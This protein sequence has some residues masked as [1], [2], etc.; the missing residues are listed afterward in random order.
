MDER[1]QQ[2]DKSLTQAENNKRPLRKNALANIPERKQNELMNVLWARMTAIFGS[3]W[4]QNYGTQDQFSFKEWGDALQYKTVPEVMNA[5]DHF[6]EESRHGNTWPPSLPDFI[7]QCVPPN[8]PRK[9]IAFQEVIRNMGDWA[10]AEWSHVIVEAAAKAVGYFNFGHMNETPLKKLW[11][12]A[13]DDAYS[14]FINGELIEI[15]KALP[16]ESEVIIK[17]PEVG[18]KHIDL[19]KKDLKF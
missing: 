12:N 14:Q 6:R 3:K 2:S 16:Q 10:E 5:I 17:N 4:I 1:D 13:F 18:R 9:E 11:S 19:I 7:A 8:L 15:K